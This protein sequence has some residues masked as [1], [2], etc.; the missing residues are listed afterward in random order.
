MPKIK[1]MRS[2]K[3]A[4]ERQDAIV[5]TVTLDRAKDYLSLCGYSAS[6]LCADFQFGGPRAVPLAA[7]AHEPMDARSAC[8]AVWA[9]PTS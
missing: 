1:M 9:A 5:S 2:P 8:I 4:A 7:F 6:L 3:G